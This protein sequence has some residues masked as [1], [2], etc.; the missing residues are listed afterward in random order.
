MELARSLVLLGLAAL[1]L[2]SLLPVSGTNNALDCCLRTSSTPIPRKLLLGYEVQRRQD[3]CPI[4]A[5]VFI[6]MRGRRLC[7]PPHA[8][9]VHHLMEKLREAY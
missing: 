8:Y 7:A 3:G 1:F 9:W 5:I 6:T 2:Q 4:H